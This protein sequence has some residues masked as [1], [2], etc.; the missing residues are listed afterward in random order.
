MIIISL[1]TGAGVSLSP[2]KTDERKLSPYVRLIAEDG[3]AITDGAVITTCKDVL[4][5]D[6]PKWTDCEVEE[7]SVDITDTDAVAIIVGGE[8]IDT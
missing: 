5:T 8:R 7:L 1:Y 6:V 2:I 3:K 4:E